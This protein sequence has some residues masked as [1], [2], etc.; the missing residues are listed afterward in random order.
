MRQG[1]WCAVLALMIGVS[2]VQAED[3]LR[4]NLQRELHEIADSMLLPRAFNLI[5]QL[6]GPSVVSIHTLERRRLRGSD[7]VVVGEGSGFVFA[8][9]DRGSL[10]VTNA[11]VVLQTNRSQDFIRNRS[12][13]PVWYDGIQI[14]TTDGRTLDAIAIGADPQTDLAVIRV[15]DPGLQPV[16]WADSDDALVGDW[17]VALGYPM[18]VGYSA[19]AGIISATARST[20][21]Y[22]GEQGYEAFLQ[23]DASINPGNSGGPLVNLRGQVV[24]VNSNI[25]SRTGAS[26]GIGFA[27]PANLARRVA[28]DL[29]DD[30]QV[31]RPRI[32]IVLDALDPDAADRLSIP[33]RRAVVVSGVVPGTPAATAGLWDGDVIIAVDGDSVSGIQQF[34]ARIAAARI[35][36]PLELRLWRDGELIDATVVPT[37]DQD[38]RARLDELRT[39]QAASTAMLPRYGLVLG[40]DD[41]PGAVIRDVR[42]G[43]PAAR[44]GLSKGHRVLRVHGLGLISGMEGLADLDRESELVI[45]IY[46]DGRQRTVRLTP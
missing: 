45:D 41:S 30:G 7:P 14:E 29:S 39:E 3:P 1:P 4:D 26:H 11:H 2:S 23:T 46:A 15:E 6:V 32:G 16:A 28:E 25:L 8:N 31:S 34:R 17:V 18:R 36:E 33:N 13:E 5:H 24:G 37:S 44:V 27:I 12:G 42:D 21:I 10:I 43:S 20:G 19:T 22:R 35:G 40:L 38:L 9:T